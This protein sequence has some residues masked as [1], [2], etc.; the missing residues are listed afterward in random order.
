MSE[1]GPE[2]GRRFRGAW[3]ERR[4]LRARGGLSPEE[5]L[6]NIGSGLG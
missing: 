3:L 6:W 5:E 1:T 4:R 2:S